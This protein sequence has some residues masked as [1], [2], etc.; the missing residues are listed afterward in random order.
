MIRSE[1]IDKPVLD[2]VHP[3][4]KELVR[5][6]VMGAIEQ[7]KAQPMTEEKFLCWMELSIDVEVVSVPTIFKGMKAVQ[8][9]ARNITDRKLVVEVLRHSEEMF[10]GVISAV[11]VGIGIV[12]NRE[13]QWVN[14]SLLHLI[15]RQKEEIIK[16]NA[17]ILLYDATRCTIKSAS[18]SM[19]IYEK[20]GRAHIEVD[21]QHK[22]G[23]TPEYLSY[24]RSGGSTRLYPEGIVIAALDITE[25]KSARKWN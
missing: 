23:S 19:T 3:D 24:R 8:V 14:D 13:V 2:I 20:R 10:R 6:R 16:N 5:Q 17:R 11:P 9:V 1:L 22:D 15:G 21:W 4:Y 12:S 18:N 25:R 7:G